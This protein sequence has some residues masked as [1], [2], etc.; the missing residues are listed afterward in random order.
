[1]LSYWVL[2][3]YF[4]CTTTLYGHFTSSISSF[5]FVSLYFPIW[6]L[7][8][9]DKMT[10]AAPCSNCQG[11]MEHSIDPYILVMTHCSKHISIFIALDKTKI[12][13]LMWKA[14]CSE[15]SGYCC[16]KPYCVTFENASTHVILALILVKN[17]FNYASLMRTS[18]AL[19]HGD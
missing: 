1:M 19:L 4:V 15:R 3:I 13:T 7:Q 9:S 5:V 12:Q 6:Q 11:Y 10:F 18:P 14:N 16:L 2:I 17:T 8:C